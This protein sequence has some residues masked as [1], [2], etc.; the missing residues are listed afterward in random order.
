MD[1]GARRLLREVI[2]ERRAAGASVV[3]ISHAL[4]DVEQL[5]DSVAVLCNGH[6]SFVGRIGE[7]ARPQTDDGPRQAA[8]VSTDRPPTPVVAGTLES[9]VAPL[10]EGAHA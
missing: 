1:L 3:L 6:L 4:D 7:L 10:Y 2:R 8:Q 9:A 5:C